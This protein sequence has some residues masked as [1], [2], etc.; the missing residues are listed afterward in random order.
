LDIGHWTL[1]IRATARA[2]HWTL[3]IGHWTFAARGDESQNFL[4]P[5]SASGVFVRRLDRRTS[6]SSMNTHPYLLIFRDGDPHLYAD[7]SADE[8]ERHLRK[9]L[10]WYENLCA[11]GKVKQG[12]P[13]E[14]EGRVVYASPK[15]GRIMD[16][17]FVETKEAIGGYFFLTVASMEE[18]T[19]IAKE[20]P[21]LEHGVMVEVRPVAS[22]CPVL[23]TSESAGAGAL[24]H[25]N[26]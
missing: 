1:V 3:V 24:K 19:L 6:I 21:G 4:A 25:P 8:K 13:L 23:D 16:G 14:R 12:H 22:M 2:G 10:A 15:T 5:L 26:S 18:A 11:E 7:M 17:P 20:C 9:W